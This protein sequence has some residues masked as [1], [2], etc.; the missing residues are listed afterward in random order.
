LLLAHP[1]HSH[2]DETDEFDF[3][4]ATFFHSHGGLDY[5]LAA[6]ALAAIAVAWFD[7]RPSV[8]ISALAAATGSIALL[9]LF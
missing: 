2:P 9:P 7:A 4:K 1:G 6:I 8:R 3:L 5:L